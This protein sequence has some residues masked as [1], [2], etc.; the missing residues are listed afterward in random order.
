MDK[1][2]RMELVVGRA[3]SGKTE[4]VLQQIRQAVQADP[5][6]PPIWWVVPPH[7][8]YEAERRLL[9]VAGSVLRVEV[10]TLD[11]L[12]QRLLPPVLPLRPLNQTGARLLLAEVLEQLEPELEVLRRDQPAV[13][14]LDAVL[15]AMRELA[16]Y[17][18][19]P[20]LLSAWLEQAATTTAHPLV[21]RRP[22]LLAKLRDIGLIYVAWR[23]A[24]E[25]YAFYDP[26]DLPSLALSLSSQ[27]PDI[28]EA[29]LLVDGFNDLTLQQLELVRELACRTARTAV[30]LRLDPHLA[31]DLDGCG[32]ET[33]RPLAELMESLGAPAKAVEPEV[34]AL[35]VRL[36][37]MAASA[38]LAPVVVSLGGAPRFCHPDLA[39]VEAC[40]ADVEEAASAA[41]RVSAMPHVALVAAANPRSEAEGA[42]QTVLEWAIKD[43]L[44]W[45]DIL[46]L[47]PDLEEYGPLLRSRF[48]EHGIPAS[49]DEFPPLA[50]PLRG[51]RAPAG[52]CH[53]C[54]ENGV[55]RP[56]ASR[57]RLAGTVR[58]SV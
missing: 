23:K 25:M 44:D 35:Y 24:L 40:L 51:G 28:G 26:Q 22:R 15:E 57:R 52:T 21:R 8:T 2:K 56:V 46:V 11:R 18:V 33:N 39:A 30:T 42:V 53:P 19:D 54:P 45:H 50:A 49:L 13:P 31:A 3:G 5:A 48:S 1:P 47:V 34:A 43:G 17:G 29:S 38:G 4:W 36:K 10:M 6:G 20:G 41:Q 58:D 16:Q 12:A 9:E 55:L 32:W 7:A 37:R 27:W 14:F